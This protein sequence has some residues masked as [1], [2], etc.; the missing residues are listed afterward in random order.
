MLNHLKSLENSGINVHALA[1]YKSRVGHVA[2]RDF[3]R[4]LSLDFNASFCKV[5]QKTDWVQ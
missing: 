1:E 3:V 5:V 2:K 4:Y